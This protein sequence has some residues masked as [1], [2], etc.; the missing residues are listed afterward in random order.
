MLEAAFTGWGKM[1]AA[2]AADWILAQP[3]GSFDSNDAIGA[4][5]IGAAQQDPEAAIA[6]TRHLDEV[7]PEQARDYGDA[8]VYALGQNGGFQ[9]AADFAAAG[10]GDLRTEWLAAAYG[11]W[12]NYQPQIAA[13]YAMEISDPDGRAEAID[14]VIPNWAQIDPKNLADFAMNNLPAGDQKNRALTD[15]LVYWAGNDTAAAA[16]WLNQAGSGPEFDTGMAAVATQQDVM[17][18]PD[19]ALSW[20]QDITDPGL[21]SRTITAILQTWALSDRSAVMNYIRNTEDLQP[22]DR[23]SLLANLTPSGQ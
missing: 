4:V 23:T 15:A 19:V 22:D 8:L 18:Q 7:N 6:L 14:A 2:R 12:A 1:D 21:R 16:A 10:S 13:A 11:N 17:K 5:L 3:K 20:A 9:L